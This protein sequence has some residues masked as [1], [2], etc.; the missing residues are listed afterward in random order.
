MPIQQLFLGSASVEDSGPGTVLSSKNAPLSFGI[1][2][3]GNNG[4]YNTWTEFLSN[5]SVLLNQNLWGEWKYD[6]S[7]PYDVSASSIS[8]KANSAR[9]WTI[10]QY[11]ENALSAYKT[12]SGRA[13]RFDYDNDKAYYYGADGTTKIVEDLDVYT[14]GSPT[15]ISSSS[16]PFGAT[17][18]SYGSIC[19]YVRKSGGGLAIFNSNSNTKILYLRNYASET[20]TTVSS[21]S[22]LDVSSYDIGGIYTHALST[23]GTKLSIWARR[24]SNSSEYDYYVWTL[25]TA[26]DLS[27]VGSPTI[28][29]S[30]GYSSG[31][32]INGGVML[33]D[34][35]ISGRALSHDIYG[36][37]RSFSYTD[38]G[39]L[40]TWTETSNLA[41][42]ENGGY[43]NGSS[44][45]IW[46]ND[47]KQVIDQGYSSSHYVYDSTSN[48]YGWKFHNMS[49]GNRSSSY[50]FIGT[51]G[52]NEGLTFSDG[53]FNA[54]RS[55]HYTN[56]Y[57]C[58]ASSQKVTEA[59]LSTPGDI[60]T[61]SS[62]YNNSN[63]STT[64]TGWNGSYTQNAGWYDKLNN[65]YHAVDFVSGQQYYVFDLNSSG[66]FTGTYTTTPTGFTSGQFSNKRYIQPLS[67]NGKYFVYFNGQTCYII[68]LD[69]AFEPARGFTQVHSF[70]I[71][72]DLPN[73]STRNPSFDRMYVSS[74][75]IFFAEYYTTT[76]TTVFDITIDGTAPDDLT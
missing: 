18:G 74:G 4:N 32:Y 62:G 16:N 40:S 33:I 52:T 51:E 64:F 59:N 43:L 48:P 20:T 54:N 45:G 2:F 57:C 35:S 44:Y 49:F 76:I 41:R 75:R 27:S 28:S 22:T 14:Q 66:E 36:K 68:F 63:S 37:L 53:R 69:H 38:S 25:S 42:Q 12:S 47:G 23:N 72:Y 3:T 7:T 56:W 15:V 6:L 65:K 19:T 50:D 70:T 46:Y 31:T 11:T 17:P 58:G 9:Y 5:G 24:S 30:G 13:M 21:S 71:Q 34:H 26:F 60:T 1:Q 10:G 39:D 67:H 55:K 61:L 8:Y 29:F 73:G